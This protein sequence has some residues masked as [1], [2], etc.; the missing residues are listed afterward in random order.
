MICI[1][2]IMYY[3]LRDSEKVNFNHK[4]HKES[5]KC[6]K[7]E[8]CISVLC[9]L[10][11]KPFGSLWLMDFNFSDNPLMGYESLK[12]YKQLSFMPIVYS[13]EL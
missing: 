8:Q 10:C 9:N 5:S 2:K 3:L 6:T 12:P 13:P 7:L 1:K 11:V 4:E